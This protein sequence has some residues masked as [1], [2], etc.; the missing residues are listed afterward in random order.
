MIDC[1]LVLVIVDYQIEL[2]TGFIGDS[3]KENRYFWKYILICIPGASKK[4]NLT[5]TLNMLN[6]TQL[7]CWLV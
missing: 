1:Q 7:A 3:T 2:H 6:F 5:I 4:T